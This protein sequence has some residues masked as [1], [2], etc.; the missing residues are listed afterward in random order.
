MAVQNSTVCINEKGDKQ[1]SGGNYSL[2]VLKNII[3]KNIM[4]GNYRK[5]SQKGIICYAW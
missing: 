4:E 5:H 2:K 3:T 1:M